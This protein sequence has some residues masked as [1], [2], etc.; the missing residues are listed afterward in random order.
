MTSQR[1]GW[2]L[3]G[4]ALV[5]LGGCDVSV[6]KCDRDDAG[7]CESIF[8]DDSG[9]DESIDASN[10]DGGR[11]DAG[12]TDA[13]SLDGSSQE[14]STLDATIDP[15]E[16]L[17][18]SE[19][20]A[21]ALAPALRWQDKL[22]EC[23]TSAA[24]GSA[25][26]TRILALVGLP[27]TG[28]SGCEGIADSDNIDFDGA[29]AS[30]CAASMAANYDVEPP[31]T[32]PSGD[33]FSVPSL[34]AMVGHGLQLPA[35]IPSCRNVFVGKLAPN[36]PCTRALECSGNLACRPAP[37]GGKT[38]QP[39][40][41]T[42]TCY[43]PDDCASGY[44]CKGQENQGGGRSCTAVTDLGLN[45]ANCTSSSECIEG[46]VCRLTDAP[47]P[48]SICQ[49]PPAASSLGATGASCEPNECRGFC[50]GTKCAPLC[51]E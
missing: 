3:L 41:V 30:L 47:N 8:D 38:C 37:G 4:S 49:A 43:G 21:A 36:A 51:A 32:C 9:F 40:L 16:P 29:K 48:V 11:S 42:G 24:N 34:E 39:Q 22:D 18:I 50:S 10:A 15:G 28:V 2:V 1:L 35:Q 5:A 46:L 25:E 23:C 12:A 19:F 31:S 33:G 7:H 26:R 20:C 17:T 45:G 6:G 27:S 14:A 13:G 44:I